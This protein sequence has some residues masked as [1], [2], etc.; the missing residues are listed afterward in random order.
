MGVATPQLVATWWA[1][2]RSWS[3]RH[4]PEKE[5]APMTTAV[6]TLTFYPIVTT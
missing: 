3:E 6:A 1:C 2:E 4:K 5:A